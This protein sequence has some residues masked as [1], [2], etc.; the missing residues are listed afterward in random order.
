MFYKIYYVNLPD[1]I[2]RELDSIDWKSCRLFFLQNFQLSPS[3]LRIRVS[4]LLL[5]VYKRNPKHIF[6]RLL[7][8][9]W[10]P[11]VS[12]LYLGFYT[13]N[14]SKVAQIA[15]CVNLLWDLWKAF[16]YINLG[17]S[18]RRFVQELDDHFNF[19]NLYVVV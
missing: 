16:L 8:E 12:P 4:D 5:P 17:L 11:L 19:R 9:I 2:D 13:Q 6:K 1:S 15:V 7:R 18:R 3:P 10:V 14:L